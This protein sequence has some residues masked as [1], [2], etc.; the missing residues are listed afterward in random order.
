MNGDK[1][2]PLKQ[3]AL[4]CLRVCDKEKCAWWDEAY[5]GCCFTN[6]SYFLGEIADHLGRRNQL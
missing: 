4:D 3:E 1:F 2:C 6:V 5:K